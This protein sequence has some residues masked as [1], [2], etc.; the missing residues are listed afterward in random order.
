MREHCGLF[1]INRC[2]A[3]WLYLDSVDGLGDLPCGAC[4][5]TNLRGKGWE[6]ASNIAADVS[7]RGELLHNWTYVDLKEFKSQG[8]ANIDRGC[9]D[10]VIFLETSSIFSVAGAEAF[11]DRPTPIVYILISKEILILFLIN[12]LLN[13]A[14]TRLHQSPAVEQGQ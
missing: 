12:I 1:Y 5:V 4:D 6:R 9:G 3:L 7:C 14:N 11:G 13:K 2:P 10:F 8:S